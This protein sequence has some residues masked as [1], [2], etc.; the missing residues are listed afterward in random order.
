MIQDVYK[1]LVYSKD[2]YA[3]WQQACDEGKDVEHL[4]DI[5]KSIQ[6][7]PE[8]EIKQRYAEDMYNTLAAAK[9]CEDFPYIEPSGLS[10]IKKYRPEADR[11]YAINLSN[12]EL[13]DKIYGAWLG[14]VCG[15][16]L[17][18]PVEGMPLEVIDEICKS[19]GNYPLSTYM[20]PSSMGE[21]FWSKCWRTKSDPAWIANIT[22]HAPNDDDTNYTALGLK[23]LEE[24][25]RDFTPNDVAESWL[26]YVPFVETC[27]AERVAYKHFVN[28]VLPPVS[29]VDHNPFREWIGAQIRADFF[30]YINPANPEAAADMAW[31]DAS[32]SHVKNGIYGEMF[33]AAMIA[34]AACTDDIKEIIA[35]GLGQIPRRCRL[36]ER[37]LLAIEWFDSGMSEDEAIYMLHEIYDQHNGHHWCHTISNA[38]IV[39][40]AL[41]YGKGDFSRS[42]C[43]AV[44]FAFD[45][46]CNGATVGSIVGML[47]GGKNV[48]KR[49]Y[50][51]FNQM[52]STGVAGH[53]FVHIKDMAQKTMEFVEIS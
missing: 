39:V 3:D 35:A 26:K 18:K 34:A 16:L 40:L 8:G 1:W 46:D 25:G 5:C 4:G 9:V 42:I 36:T 2:V 17:G 21:D 51:P 12:D 19:T 14:R 43:L 32:I 22:S 38:M 45:T 11:D 30:G 23:I 29:A 20:D 28:G 13:A 53:N 47:T 10:D 31:R 24:Y 49:W 44:R 50:E 15:C 6:E 52:F 37:V 41:L 27:T 48:P 7:M 33:A